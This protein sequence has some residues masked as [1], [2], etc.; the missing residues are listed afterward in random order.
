MSRLL[1]ACCLLTSSAAGAQT[2]ASALWPL[3]FFEADPA[4]LHRAADAVDHPD[5]N[6]QDIVVLSSDWHVRFDDEG[7]ETTTRRL[8]YQVK[9]Q[10]GLGLWDTVA[11]AWSPW[12]QQRP[13]IR[14]RVVGRD[15]DISLL[16]L[17]TLSESAVTSS[18]IDIF[19]DR[20]QVE[21]PLPSL[22]VGAIVEEEAI[23]RDV[24]PLFR[25][26]VHSRIGLDSHSL[27]WSGSVSIEW[28]ASLPL[29]Y[30][31]YGLD[32][33]SVEE[34]ATD[35][36]T[37]VT[38]R[39][40]PLAAFEWSVGLP[41]DHPDRPSVAYST[42]ATW[43]DVASSYDDW[44]DDAIDRGRSAREA[45]DVAARNVATSKPLEQMDAALAWV[46]ERVRYTGLELGEAGIRPY[47]PVETLDR[48]YGDCKDQATLLVAALRHM[49]IPS[50][51]AL[52]RAG[53]DW[54]VPTD[55]P[56][57]GLF[58]HAI[59]YVP[60]DPDGD[61]GEIWID[62]TIPT[63]PAGALPSAD[64]G[65]WALIADRDTQA[66]IKIPEDDS[67]SNT[68]TVVRQVKMADYGRGSVREEHRSTGEIASWMR[69]YWSDLS[70]EEAAMELEA[71]L[72]QVHMA[73]E[74]TTLE[75]SRA[76]ELRQP[77]RYGFHVPSSGGVV[78]D[79][80]EAMVALVWSDLF[81]HVPYEW[82]SEEEATEGSTLERHTGYTLGT[83][84][85]AEVR[86]VIEPALGMVLRDLPEN[87]DLSW[88]D[89]RFSSHFADLDGSVEATFTLDLPKRHYSAEEFVAI[90]AGLS[91]LGERDAAVIVSFDHQAMLASEAGDLRPALIEH[92]R[93]IDAQPDNPLHRARRG[94]SYLLGGMVPAAKR[95]AYEAVRLDPTSA[96][97]HWAVGVSEQYRD[98]GQMSPE[99]RRDAAQQ[100]LDQAHEIAPDDAMIVSSLAT[101]HEYDEH[102]VQ[103]SADANLERAIE[104]HRR[105]REDTGDGTFDF[106][107]LLDLMMLG[108][109]R[110]VRQEVETMT[111]SSQHHVVRLAALAVERGAQ[112]AAAEAARLGLGA[113]ARQEILAQSAWVLMRTGRYDLA[114]EVVERAATTSAQP[115]TLREL[116]RLLR[117]VRTAAERLAAE[118][119]ENR[120]VLGL[121]IELIRPEL[122][123]PAIAATLH[124]VLGAERADDLLDSWGRAFRD[125]ILDTVDLE[126]RAGG[127]R[128]P[129]E[130][131][132]ALYLGA[133]ELVRST[134][135]EGLHGHEIEL[136]M[137]GANAATFWVAPLDEPVVND[138]YGGFRVVA[139][140]EFPAP[141][142]SLALQ[143][144]DDGNL[145]AAESWLDRLRSVAVDAPDD[146]LQASNF[147]WF[148]PRPEGAAPASAI[149]IRVAAAVGLAGTR[150]AARAV[151]T[152]E[153]ELANSRSEPQRHYRLRATKLDAL[154]RLE[155]F[156][157]AIALGKELPTLSLGLKLELLLAHGQLNQWPDVVSMCRQILEDDADN[158]I[159]ASM[160]PMA[161]AGG[162]DLD[163]AVAAARALL[164][165][166]TA[167]AEILNNLA[168]M[169]TFL[170]PLPQWAR[171][172]AERAVT[173]SGNGGAALHTLAMVYAAQGEPELAWGA[174][175]QRILQNHQQRAEPVDWVVFG[176]IAQEYG[177][178]ADA[179]MFY[180][181]SLEAPAEGPLP[182]PRLA[183]QFLDRLESTET[184][185]H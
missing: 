27:T 9:T 42:G 93:L 75:I 5:A 138:A 60:A 134:E 78:T 19:S 90:R 183:Q 146:P 37:R 69:A 150:L 159:A 101:L 46:N 71:H 155:R 179:R 165:T 59:V 65:R 15:G 29:Q 154:L 61:H 31:R 104:L 40:G 102:G 80:R 32:N 57:L 145:E 38:I 185:R 67:S 176:R 89:V 106:N 180:E 74:L 96:V 131:V 1:L 173:V 121:F 79:L 110:E 130:T 177:L 49:D 13:A 129:S 30:R 133:I 128:F 23:I 132:E 66:L 168:W 43:A 148:W 143:R 4:D 142:A 141:A 14:A 45:I 167:D 26:G 92:Q 52:L 68:L 11:Y 84:L 20:R 35:T 147:S 182:V 108:K 109:V 44:V 124:P 169:S 170:H 6:D 39:H 62:P 181:R 123:H 36:G 56:G 8:V 91:E 72:E 94:Y 64:Q 85:R 161:L 47:T 114:A 86:Y 172:I 103:F 115:A 97:A 54:D 163:A 112:R 99:R 117:N 81:Q 17:A 77:F 87:E 70:D 63:V 126:L 140:T 83:P 22:S 118:P 160:L 166:R 105:Y 2:D 51:V 162:G 184:D 16:D 24:E 116:A 18:A 7:R 135:N 152:I 48:G 113:A 175:T 12:Y 149:D 164:E 107:L 25:A 120:S 171:D 158:P 137:N 156:Q 50:H 111:P 153:R 119:P 136:R 127:T 41:F 98:D 144:L 178:I 53:T 10:N 125:E 157:D 88:A 3:R 28:P 21:A 122:D 33:A 73:E 100:A 76:S 95:D 139:V 174:I 55:L 34:A 58:N 151:E 82:V